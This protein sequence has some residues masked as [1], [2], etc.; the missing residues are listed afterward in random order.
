MGNK[1]QFSVKVK[2]SRDKKDKDIQFTKALKRWK[3]LYAEFQIK[4]ELVK[5]QQFVKPSLVK[6]KQMNETIRNHKRQELKRKENE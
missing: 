2:P 3:R 4:E 1:P 5:R 6:R